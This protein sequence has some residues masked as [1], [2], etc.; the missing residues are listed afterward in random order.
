[1]RTTICEDNGEYNA[2]RK[3]YLVRRELVN[4]YLRGVKKTLV[5]NQEIL[6]SL[7]V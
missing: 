3:T 6:F 2:E 1:M 5:E 4:C 7:D